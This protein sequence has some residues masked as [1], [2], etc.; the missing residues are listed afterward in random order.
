MGWPIINTHIQKERQSL[1]S[2]GPYSHWFHNRCHQYPGKQTQNTVDKNNID[3]NLT[4]RYTHAASIFDLPLNLRGLE[5]LREKS[6]VSFLHA[7]IQEA[8][9]VFLSSLLFCCCCLFVFCREHVETKQT[10]YLIGYSLRS[11]LIWESLVCYLFLVVFKLCFLRFKCSDPVLGF[12]LPTQAARASPVCLIPFL[13]NY[14]N[15]YQN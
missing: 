8:I 6:V 7:N 12:S 10:N 9:L 13:F 2:P 1:D 15:T 4:H 11:C 3:A 5:I 14:F